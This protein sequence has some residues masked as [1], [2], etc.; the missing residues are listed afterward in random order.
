MR[1]VPDLKTKKR[2]LWRKKVSIFILNQKIRIVATQF[3]LEAFLFT[4]FSSLL[5]TILLNT[6]C[7]NKIEIFV[8]FLD[9]TYLLKY[10]F[11]WKDVMMFHIYCHFKQILTSFKLSILVQHIKPFI[12]YWVTITI[13]FSLPYGNDL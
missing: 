5:L 1:C 6:Y 12:L 3:F 2:S 8:L 11:F 9:Y 13:I 4:L 7:F 10:K